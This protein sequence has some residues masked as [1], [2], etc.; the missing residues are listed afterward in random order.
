MRVVEPYII[1][2]C[3]CVVL[4]IFAVKDLCSTLVQVIHTGRILVIIFQSLH[5][6]FILSILTTFFL[7]WP[8]PVF[9][10]LPAFSSFFLPSLARSVQVSLSYPPSLYLCWQLLLTVFLAVRMLRTKGVPLIYFLMTHVMFADGP[11][12]ELVLESP[13][14]SA[15]SRRFSQ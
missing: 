8:L 13:E 5:L 12:A 11:P 6:F 4:V 15:H 1:F 3:P 2:C 9:S 7:L 14:C 10:D